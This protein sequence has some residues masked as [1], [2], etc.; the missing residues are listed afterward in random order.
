LRFLVKV[1]V[2]YD[3]KYG[4]TKLA[5]E[6]ILE[7]IGEV[8]GFETA[9]GYVKEIDVRQVADYDAMVLGAPNHMGRPSR[10][11]KKFVDQLSELDLKAKDVAVFGTYSGTVRSPDRAVKKLELMIRK[12]LP[13]LSLILPGLS[14]RVKGIPGPIVDG[15]LPKCVDFGK[16]IASQLKRQ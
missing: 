3:S 13:N 5:A 14:I 4:N 16:K 15:E 9:I 6:K 1:F 10:T 7:G 11:M 2:I 8:E 12:K